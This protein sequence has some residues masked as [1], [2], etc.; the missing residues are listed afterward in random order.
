MKLS[1]IFAILLLFP[2]LLQAED[3]IK[4]SKMK[5]NPFNDESNLPISTLEITVV[6]CAPMGDDGFFDWCVIKLSE[7]QNADKIQLIASSEDGITVYDIK[8]DLLFPMSCC[9]DGININFD[10]QQVAS[11]RYGRIEGKKY[12]CYKMLMQ[13]N[14][15]GMDNTNNQDFIKSTSINKYIYF[16]TAC[17]DGDI[18]RIFS[19]DGIELLHEFFNGQSSLELSS[20]PEGIYILNIQRNNTQLFRSKIILKH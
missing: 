6:D 18:I 17:M 4:D 19:L 8:E 10:L 15:T 1:S 9:V 20:Y 14:A 7:V 3:I 11:N 2:V 16:G 12:D 13:Y 5:G